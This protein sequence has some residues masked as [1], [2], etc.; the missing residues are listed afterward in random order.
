[1]TVCPPRGSNTALNHLL[2]KVKDVNFTNEERQE[3]LGIADEVFFEIPNKEHTKQMAELVSD[4]HMRSIVNGLAR[5]PE[6][7]EK[8]R[9]TLTPFALEGNFE[10]PGCADPDY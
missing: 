3:L 5:V 6:V 1:M 10:T 4:D 8:G 2:E 7:D 9:V